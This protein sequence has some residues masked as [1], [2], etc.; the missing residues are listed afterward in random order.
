MKMPS[1]S[2]GKKI[3]LP[4]SAWYDSPGIFMG[5][6]GLAAG[7]FLSLGGTVLLKHFQEACK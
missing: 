4:S 5:F 1:D 2:A 6:L 7:V 3:M